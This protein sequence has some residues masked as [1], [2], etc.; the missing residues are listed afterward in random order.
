MLVSLWTA[1]IGLVFI[2][3]WM[4]F[5]RHVS[6]SRGHILSFG[7]ER[8]SGSSGAGFPPVGLCYLFC[9]AVHGSQGMYPILTYGL[10]WNMCRDVSERMIIITLALWI[11]LDTAV[12]A[13]APILHAGMSPWHQRQCGHSSGNQE[14]IYMAVRPQGWSN[15]Q[16]Y[17]L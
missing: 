10:L 9:R 13:A 16:G 17:L 14:Q 2:K 6:G 5:Y 15:I 11:L 7:V 4:Q 12:V 8:F 3:N 1:L